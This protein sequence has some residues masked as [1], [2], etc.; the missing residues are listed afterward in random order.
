METQ[1]KTTVRH[2]D[3]PNGK[4]Q[5]LPTH[6][7]FIYQSDHYAVEGGPEDMVLAREFEHGRILYYRT[8]FHGQI[9]T[10]LGT[11]NSAFHIKKN[12]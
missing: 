5:L 12:Q 2:A 6:C 9:Q 4:V 3:L 8:D 11:G 7:Y 1:P 10:L